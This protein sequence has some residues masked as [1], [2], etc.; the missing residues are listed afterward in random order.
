[1]ARQGGHPEIAKIGKET[2]FKTADGLNEKMGNKIFSLRLPESYQVKLLSYPP[3]TRVS[4][5]RSSLM[6]AID[7][8]EQNEN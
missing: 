7:E 4:L 3:K 6:K 1:M 8:V 2:R 5:M